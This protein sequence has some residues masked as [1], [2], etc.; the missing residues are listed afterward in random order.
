MLHIK[1]KINQTKRNQPKLE[2]LLKEND[3]IKTKQETN[4]KK[5]SFSAE[6]LCN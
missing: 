6:A 4:G 1:T 2:I 5:T 3:E